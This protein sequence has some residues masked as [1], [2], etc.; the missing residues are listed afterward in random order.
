MTRQAAEVFVILIE[1]YAAAGVAFALLF[2]WRGVTRT[3][4]I[5]ATSPWTFRV[6]ILPGCAIFWPLLLVRWASGSGAPPVESTA[7]RVSARGDR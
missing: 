5:A 7:H 1:G 3:D 2:V 6:L 4:P